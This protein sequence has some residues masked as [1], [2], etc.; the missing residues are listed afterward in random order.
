MKN[1]LQKNLEKSVLENYEWFSKFSP[2][3]KLRIAKRASQFAKILK[4]IGSKWRK[5]SFSS[6]Q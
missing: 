4:E 2:V 3:D 1:K 6:N 5:K